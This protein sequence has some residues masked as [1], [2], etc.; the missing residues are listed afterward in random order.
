MDDI[1]YHTVA[2]AGTQDLFSA[3]RSLLI[4][5][6]KAACF[7]PGQLTLKSRTDVFLSQFFV[8]LCLQVQLDQ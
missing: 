4:M 1:K 8:M 2:A 6:Q 3:S 7:I 5:A